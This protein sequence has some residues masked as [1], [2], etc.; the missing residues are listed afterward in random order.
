MAQAQQA[1]SH[2]SIGR[3]RGRGSR[4]Q[5]YTPSRRPGEQ[6][7]P[8][9]DQSTAEVARVETDLSKCSLNSS[10]PENENKVPSSS[11]AGTS[12]PAR[13]SSAATGATSA[14]T[15]SPARSA[16]ATSAPSAAGLKAGVALLK[17]K[18]SYKANPDSPLGDKEL[19]MK[20]GQ[21]LVYLETSK[22]NEI[23]WKVQT[24]DG[25][26]QGFVPSSYMEVVAEKV[27]QLPWLAAKQSAEEAELPKC[28]PVWKAYVSAYNREGNVTP[29][30]SSPASTD[31]TQYYCKWCA[32]QLN[33]P[34]PYSAHIHSKAHKE[35][36]QLAKE[37]GEYTED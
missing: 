32:K 33:G 36:V 35:E 20:Q 4:Q 30:N 8:S 29:G 1:I 34:H 13:S 7:T 6:C 25:S 19:T 26:E 3:G 2:W 14:G 18:F 10:R 31:L 37:N 27:T 12:S 5:P 24:K 17:A 23:W 9:T 22:D 15:S 16:S 28:K 11:S 21:N